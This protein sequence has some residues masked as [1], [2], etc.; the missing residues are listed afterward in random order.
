M[1]D[2]DGSISYKEDFDNFQKRLQDL[3]NVTT[4]ESS[5][6]NETLYR[7]NATAITSAYKDFGVSNFTIPDQ[8]DDIASMI[9]YGVNGTNVGKILDDY[10]LPTT[11]NYTIK[12]SQGKQVDASISYDEVNKQNTL[13][14]TSTAASSTASSTK[15]SSKTSSASTSASTSS[16]KGKKSKGAAVAIAPFAQSGVLALLISALL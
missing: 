14:G 4:T 11:F 7:C 3:K 15:A 16:K 13:K 9:K 6:K 8:P 2:S 12:D 10:S 5:I 1:D